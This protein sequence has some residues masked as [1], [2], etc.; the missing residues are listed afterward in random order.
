MFNMTLQELYEFLK[1]EGCELRIGFDY[2]R[3]N[4]LT[5]TWL[6]K[7]NNKQ[8]SRIFSTFE[9]EM[10]RVPESMLVYAR[11]QAEECLK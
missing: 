3:V 8:F 5:L 1:I 11:S 2:P 4:E 6:N 9:L 10:M 7:N